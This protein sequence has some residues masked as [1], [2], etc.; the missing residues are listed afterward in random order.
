MEFNL[1]KKRTIFAIIITVI[2]VIMTNKI[3]LIKPLFFFDFDIIGKGKCNVKVQL[4]KKDK[5]DFEKAKSKTIK[6]D[7]SKE[8]HANFEIK[9]VKKVKRI[10]ITISKLEDNS[11]FEIK[12]IELNKGKVKLNDLEQF[13]SKDS[14]LVV[15]NNTLVI[16]PKDNTTELIYNKKL[17]LLHKSIFDFKVFVIILVLSYLFVYK[18]T[19]YVAE[20]KTTKK[21][22]R[23]EI[24]F[25]SVFFVFLFIPM[26]N[27]SQ[28][29]FTKQEN[30][31]LA[32]WKPLIN[33]DGEINYEFGKNFN[34]W[35]SDRF[36][37]REKLI[38][39]YLRIRYNLALDYAE[40]PRGYV[41]KKSGWMFY[42]ENSKI[43]VPF[44]TEETKWM[45]KNVKKLANYCKNNNIKLYILV[46]PEKE[47]LYKDEDYVNNNNKTFDR[48]QALADYV[49]QNSNFEIIY[50][51]KELEKLKEKEY[52]FYKTD[53]HLTDS[54]Q[55]VMY[56]VLLN[57]IK[58]EYND[59]PITKEADFN[60]YYNNLARWNNKR[61]FKPGCNYE[62]GYLND[63][64]LL[65]SQYKHFDY[66]KLSDIKISG[67]Q[68]YY[69]HI[70]PN[71]KYNLFIIGNSFSENLVYFLNTSFKRID[72]YRFNLG[73]D[74]P[75]R[76]A[77]LDFNGY[78]PIIEKQKPDILLIVMSAGFLDRLKDLYDKEDK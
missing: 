21:K 48:T 44:D 51:I 28:D 74:F 66:K 39:N 65:K 54:G 77:F 37:F 24:I 50:P 45:A 57:K 6:L 47:L 56:N 7:L 30:R 63:K 60:T 26:S 49:K 40:V 75:K 18:L 78:E 72:K 69:L 22:S 1:K 71:G 19:D 43:F 59:I 5:L 73:L 32:T 46:A 15:K 23:I 35:F 10:K 4:N 13:S 20:F 31:T 62:R 14:K 58:Q 76:K 70:N 53:N 64:N 12:N 33:Q 2:I 36:C 25:L 38:S 52:A 9:K 11:Q 41:Y 34:E 67:E 55:F 29:N 61:E 17:N 8:N 3:W 42:K 16:Y 27:I 68:P